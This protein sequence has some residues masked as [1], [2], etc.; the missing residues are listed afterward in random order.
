MKNVV[1]RVI[2]DRSAFHGDRFEVIKSSALLNLHR[3]GII[4]VYHTPIFLDE[5]L[6][7]YGAGEKAKQWRDHL[8]Y[9]LD[10]CNGIFLDRDEIWHN[11][12]AVGRGP[13]ARY[14]LPESPNK[15][16]D[17]RPRLV[18]TLREKATSG[19]VSKEWAES[20]AMR[21]ETHVK[22]DNQRAIS[23]EVR[24]TVATALKE[25]RV[26]GSVKDYRFDKFRNAELVRTGRQLMDLV[27]KKRAGALMDQWTQNPARYPFYSAFVEGFLYAFYYAATEHSEPLDRNAQVDYEL[28]AHLTWA[29]LVVSD[30]QKF[31][32]RAFETMWK[33]RGKRLESAEGFAALMDRLV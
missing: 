31:F 12:L 21:K 14:L 4:E 24:Q 8:L 15:R 13:F 5:T 23:A 2:F 1:F 33:P 9:C 6:S 10:I 27:D 18:E 28:L 26:L 30:D 20:A 25:R 19:D 11:E 29:D 16:Y 32:R 17:S 22:K 7:S 3:R